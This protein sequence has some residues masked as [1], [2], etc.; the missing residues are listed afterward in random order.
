[1]LDLEKLKQEDKEIVEAQVASTATHVYEVL[2]ADENTVSEMDD[3]VDDNSNNP[4]TLEDKATG[5]CRHGGSRRLQISVPTRWNSALVMIRSVLDLYKP[6]NEVLKKIGHFDK[7]LDEEDKETLS[8]LLKFLTPFERFTKIFSQNAPTLSLI[9][10]IIANIRYL[11]AVNS[12]DS[13]MLKQLKN[14]TVK[15]SGV[16]ILFL[17]K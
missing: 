14:L 5:V 8:E 9:P 10:L 4:S 1:M 16:D 13:P 17:S 11:C 2:E 6:I 3:N 12:R 7:C 15:V